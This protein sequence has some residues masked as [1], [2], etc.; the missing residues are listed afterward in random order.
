MR[1]IAV[2]PLIAAA[3]VASHAAPMAGF[4][5]AAW[6]ND[7]YG[8]NSSDT[9]IAEL[10]S[11]GVKHLEIVVTWYLNN[12]GD[13]NITRSPQSTPCDASLLHAIQT[14]QRAGI[15]PVLK[16]HVDVLDGTWRGEIGL[17][18][19]TEAQWSAW[20]SSYRSFI[21]R[22]AQLAQAA[23]ASA[24]NVGTELDSTEFREADWRSVIAD[25]RSIFSAG[26]IWYGCNWSPGTGAVNWWDALD[27]IGVDAYFPLAA[28]PD[29]SLAELLAGWQPVL[30]QLNATAAKWGKPIVFAE[31]GYAS[32]PQAAEEPWACCSGSP[33][34]ASQGLL[35]EAFFKAVWPQPWF[36]GVFWWAW[37]A[38]QPA[39]T[40]QSTSFDVFGKPAWEVL[41]SY[42]G[43]GSNAALV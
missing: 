9:V 4:V 18:Y 2:L 6:N 3:G 38:W 19:T 23:N 39:P 26:P 22:Y 7:T 37:Y 5:L 24:F 28:K 33:D 21:T 20:W 8:T 31:I 25:V 40:P 42:Y 27:F 16:P 12:L 32:F 30:A 15:A 34:P 29:P 14:A 1:R 35:Y 13:T 17:N 43:A 11:G 10:R 36:G 41:R